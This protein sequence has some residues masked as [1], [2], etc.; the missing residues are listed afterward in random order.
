MLRRHL[1][2]PDLFDQLRRYNRS[3]PTASL[4]LLGGLGSGECTQAGLETTRAKGRKGG[5]RPSLAKDRN[6]DIA[7]NVLSGRQTG[8]EM[9][10][11]RMLI[12]LICHFPSQ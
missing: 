8:E 11:F 1:H 7:A 2:A 5:S 6:A 12:H 10:R 3:C 4:D 9:A